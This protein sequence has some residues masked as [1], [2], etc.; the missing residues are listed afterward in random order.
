M[1]TEEVRQLIHQ[2]E[3]T[4]IEFKE[5]TT[6]VPSSFYE[7]V[8]SF[9]NKEGGTVLL[10]VA[11]DGS[12]LGIPAER[13][14][15]HLKSIVSA[16]NDSILI[17]PPTTLQP[18]AVTLPSG[19][20]LIAVKLSVSS[21]VHKCRGT[22]YDREND[23]DLAVTDEARIKELYFRK[24]QVF[25]EGEI[26][27]NLRLEDLD[28]KLFEKAR[29]LIRGANPEHPWL[30]YTF[31]ELLRS[32]LLYR[33]DFQ[34]GE[35]GL[36]LAAALIFGRDEV[37][38]SILSA[39]KVEAIVRREDLDRYDDRITLRTNLIDTYLQLMD[40][41]R[42]HLP[43]RFALLD[44]QRVE[45]REKIFRELVGN[46]IVH[47]EYTNGVATHLEIYRDRVLA[48]NPNRAMFRGALDVKKFS[49]YA[50]NPNLRKFFTAFGWTDEIGSGVRN[51]VKFLAYYVPGAAPLF[52]ENDLFTT[53]IP[54]VAGV[55]L[56]QYT[57]VLTEWL[58]I[59]PEALPHIS[60]GLKKVIL[61]SRL[62]GASWEA[63]LLA[64]VPS[65]YQKG[66]RLTELDWPS[67]Q[68]FN[69]GG[70]EKVPGLGAKGTNPQLT[71]NGFLD[72]E[73]QEYLAERIRRVPGW[74]E[75]GT[76]LLHKKALYLLSILV[77]T[78]NP[79]KLEQLMLWMGYSNRA[80]FRANYLLPLQVSGLL[81]RTNPENPSDPEQRY[82]LTDEGRLFLG[83]RVL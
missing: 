25:T 82:T 83:G 44:D 11:D 43:T 81:T 80:T 15:K 6:D 30:N 64:L 16:G 78:A 33:R 18:I 4:R 70:G 48:T 22:H 31:E 79:V 39:Y 17:D 10:G 20:Q 49:P 12:I 62:A 41:V 65:W 27:K 2:G 71:L 67:K 59:T 56:D 40:F 45:V 61:D 3:G 69:K 60:T 54:L 23:S 63:L 7:T 24:R 13:V 35:E 38:Q 73:A 5:A 77:L 72:E 37:I 14:P 75:K 50:K 32:S 36:T 8:C 42:K 28:P 19:H 47:R 46:I 76:N 29:K 74:E 57:N 34:S 55:S 66:I 51:V 52:F 21:Q 1:T 26:F 9:L 53:E 68:P 58:G